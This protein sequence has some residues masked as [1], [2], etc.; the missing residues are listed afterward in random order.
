METQ[1]E[2]FADK[3]KL[4]NQLIGMMKELQTELNKNQTIQSF[5][6]LQ[7]TFRDDLV[8]VTTDKNIAQTGSYQLEVLQL[9]P[10]IFCHEQWF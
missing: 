5:R 1:K 3:M 4:L 10:K 6:E 7:A 8:E 9:A 2:K